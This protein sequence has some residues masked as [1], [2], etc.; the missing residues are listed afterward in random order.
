MKITMRKII[1]LLIGMVIFIICLK[2]IYKTFQW[3]E[4][5]HILRNA[6]LLWLFVAGSCAIL[7]FW[8]FR[9]LRWFVLLKVLGVQVGFLK[10]YFCTAMSLT[11]SILTP[12]QSGE[13]LKIELLR[14]Q[15]MMDR[16]LGYGSLLLERGLDVF[17]ISIIAVVGIISHMYFDLDQVSFWVVLVGFM[18]LISLVISLLLKITTWFITIEWLKR[19]SLHA[20]D[21]RSIFIV[22]VLTFCSWIMVAV[23]WQFCL[24][25]ISI[26]LELGKTLFMVAALSI[27]N[28]LSFIPG[29]LGI[30]EAGVTEFLLR[31]D[32]GAALS[33]TG[34]II[35]RLQMFLVVFLG[36]VHYALWKY[37][38]MGNIEQQN[39]PLG[40]LK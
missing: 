8:F 31:F 39:R 20:Y 37:W 17:A 34:A 1:L 14:R 26:H 4:I 16:S 24:F 23:S 25:S 2:Y 7:L 27:I 5:A 15:G 38:K 3:S 33:Q 22:M 18:T 19:S 12:L 35:L 11:V 40:R 13:I 32:Q 36:A 29:G 6:K 10:L 21:S 30:F 28:V 9:S